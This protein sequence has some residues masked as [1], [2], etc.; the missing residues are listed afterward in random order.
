MFWCK[1]LFRYWPG[2]TEKNTERSVRIAALWADVLT[3]VLPNTKFNVS[4]R[5]VTRADSCQLSAVKTN[6]T[7]HT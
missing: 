4:L 5:S 1:V 2:G 3:R 7:R 6:G